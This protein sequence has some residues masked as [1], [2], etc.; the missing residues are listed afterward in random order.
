MTRRGIRIGRLRLRNP[1]MTASGTCG[2]GVELARYLDIATLGAVCTKGLSL[3]PRIGNR[4]PRICETPAGMLNAIGLANIGVEAFVRDKLPAL[5]AAGATVVANV[6]GETVEEFVQVARR[7]AGE[8]GIHA[9]ELN[10]SCPNVAKGGL[11]FGTDPARLADVTRAVRDAVDLTVIVKLPPETADVGALARSAVDAGADALSV[12]NT[13]RGMAI[14]VRTRRPRIANVTGGLSGPAVRP[15]T[16][17]LVYEV[18]RAVPAPVIGVGGVAR[19]EDAAEM[20]LAGASAVQVGSASFANPR[21]PL[22]V[23]SGLASF[24]RRQG[25]DYAD[26]VGA[27]RLD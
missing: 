27:V 5:R 3:R 7:L 21:A 22:E 25:I 24:C 19:W 26:L 15:I 23:L 6:F 8:Q 11:A 20:M 18:S 16:V 9:L 1:V 14:D 17:R 10:V 4:P 2:Y 13:I 12:M